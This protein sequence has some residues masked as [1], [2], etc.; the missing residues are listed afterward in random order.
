VYYIQM[1]HARLAGIFRV[2]G[3]DPTALSS[4]IDFAI[5]SLPEETE[6]MKA[7]LDF[8]ALVADAAEA[9]EPHRIATY[10]HDT[11]GQ[12]HLWYHKAHVLNEP[13]PVTRARLLLARAAQIVLRNGLTMLGISAPDRM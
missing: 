2:G 12:V 10:L 8:P 13:E 11:A 5:L 1:A 3:I 4:E 7:L 6:L 9:L